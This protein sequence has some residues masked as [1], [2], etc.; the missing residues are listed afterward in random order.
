VDTDGILHPL[1]IGKATVTATLGAL[2]SSQEVTVM[3]GHLIDFN[4]PT[5]EIGN[6][7]SLPSDYQPVPGLEIGYENIGLFN[8][9]PDHTT[10]LPGVNR[11]NVYQLSEAKPQVFTF[12]YP[13][14]I[15]VLSLAT[16]NG[17]GSAITVTAYGDTAGGDLIGS[18]F[19]TPAKSSGP[20]HYAWTECTNLNSAEYKGQIRRLEIS[21]TDNAN[22]DDLVVIINTN[23]GTLRSINLS[24]SVREMFPGM[25]RPATVQARYDQLTS[26]D[27]TRAPGIVYRTSD[28]NVL[29][30]DPAG[31]VSAIG[32]GVA[33]ITASF[34]GKESHL[35][36]SVQ[37]AE[38]TLVSFN[39]MA[40]F[41]N[42]VLIPAGYQPVPGLTLKYEN[43]GIYNGGPD[44]TFG[45]VGG[46]N[47][48]SYQFRDGLPQVIMFSKPVSLPSFWLS[49][50]WGSGDQISVNT[51]SDEEGKSLLGT[52]FVSTATFLGP[53]NYQWTECTNL[54][55]TAYNGRIRRIELLGNTGNAQLDDILV[56]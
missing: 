33:E 23:H 43:V 34:D 38:G 9:G 35:N 37:R 16:Y 52:I 50:Y 24:L 17:S 21:G 13:V 41:G 14:S 29:T 55:A 56:R 44:H 28:K 26:C 10:G 19:F 32:P 54:N 22:L 1:G 15:P 48:S 46:N 45:V 30:V 25:S 49:T 40:A 39:Q 11:Y 20:G 7:V 18:V 2:N 42:K 47:Y 36:V 53:G 4:L 27:V 3:P 6:F 8:G 5:G 51:Y 31:L 12:N